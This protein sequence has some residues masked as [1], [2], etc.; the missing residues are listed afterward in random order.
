MLKGKT[1]FVVGAGA[2]KELNLPIGTELAVKISAK[3]DVLFNDWG[4]EIIQGDKDLF[5]NVTKGAGED[6]RH[7]SLWQK[8]AWVI[9]DGII[10]AHSIDDFLDAHKH[11]DR[12]VSYGKAA[13][14]KCILEAEADSTLF[15]NPHEPPLIPGRPP[16][17]DM[18]KCANSWLVG[19]MR[20]LV[21]QTPFT[22][23][24]K[25]LDQCSFVVFNYD[26]CVEHFFLHALQSFYDISEPEA[27][28]IVRKARIY[29]PY[30]T[31]G[32]LDSLGGAAPRAGFGQRADFYN[33]GKTTL[34]TYTETV[35]SNAIHEAVQQAE[36][37]VFLG[38]A[39]HDQNM[40][41]LARDRSIKVK[42]MVGTAF[43]M[44][45]SD[46]NVVL[47]QIGGWAFPEQF[48]ENMI[49]QVDLRDNLK[50]ADI[51]RE[52]SKSL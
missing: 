42:N 9:R 45:N 41:I 1:V 36:K 4:S 43:Q 12:V 39:F 21:R 26:R 20:L 11:N 37:I 47:D 32:E 34:K 25:I 30:G 14:A 49:A 7:T 33:V 52:Y 18:K 5:L 44:S 15:F 50:A 19:L 23:R 46:I 17:I 40:A 35:E 24:A 2:S 28:D 48:R 3:L 27:A 6:G 51:F 38:F 22:E 16:T 10:L 8:A 31:P 29:H 13:I